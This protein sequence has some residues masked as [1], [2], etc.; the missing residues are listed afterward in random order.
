MKLSALAFLLAAGFAAQAK[1]VDI[2]M[3][4]N[5]ADGMMTF[6]PGFVQVKPGD[7]VTFVPTDKT[8]SSSSAFTPAGAKSWTGK[9]DQKI[10]VKLDKEGL[11]I[12]KCDPHLPMAM[13]GVIQ[14]G[15]PVNLD[16]AK[17][18]AEKMSKNFAVSK[19]RLT[20]YLA[21]AK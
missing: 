18:E 10:T 11:Y 7:T 14:V 9:M 8:H 15:K 12:Y 21:Q 3:K 16:A 13:A 20:K 2:L 6:E 4:N 5:G 17:Q 1:N 19:D